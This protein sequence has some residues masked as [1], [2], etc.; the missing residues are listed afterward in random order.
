MSRQ[1]HYYKSIKLS[2]GSSEEVIKFLD[3]ATRKVKVSQMYARTRSGNNVE[4]ILLGDPF[5]VNLAVTE[6]RKL[7]KTV[8]EMYRRTRGVSTYDQRVILESARLEAAIPLDVVFKILEFQGHK[9]EILRDGRVR[10]DASLREIVRLV[11]HVSSLYKEMMDMDITPQAKRIVAIYSTVMDRDLEDAI[12]DLLMFDILRTY[13][14]EERSLIVLSRSYEES[15]E[16]LREVLNMLRENPEVLAR[17]DEERR[18]LRRESESEEEELVESLRD[19]IL[20]AG[21]IEFRENE[22]DEGE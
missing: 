18:R 9:V 15:L 11:E 21:G 13:E 5:E 19:R 17:L 12:S 8:R 2:F 20:G 10:T 7:A 4:I 1:R 16:K 6:L 3:L 22:N 14:S